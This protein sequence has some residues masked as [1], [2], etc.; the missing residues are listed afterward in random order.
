MGRKLNFFCEIG[1]ILIGHPG[2]ADQELPLIQTEYVH[3]LSADGLHVKFNVCVMDRATKEKQ[4]SISVSEKSEILQLN[5]TS[6]PFGR[7]TAFPLEYLYLRILVI[8]SRYCLAP[9]E[10]T[11]VASEMIGK[12]LP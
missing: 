7:T 5:A 8:H 9:R 11:R 10:T 3:N 1:Q 4:K 12:A 6:K 2:I